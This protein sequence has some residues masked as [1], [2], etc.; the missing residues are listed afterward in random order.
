MAEAHIEGFALP[1]TVEEAKTR[2]RIAHNRVSIINAFFRKCDKDKKPLTQ[3]EV[4]ERAK[5]RAEIT[6]LEAWLKAKSKR[7]V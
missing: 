7:T 3:M 2:L 1:G 4:E 6:N 5:L